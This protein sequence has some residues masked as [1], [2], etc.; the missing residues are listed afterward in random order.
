MK[1]AIAG[2]GI[3]GLSAAMRLRN[4]HDVV[5][6]ERAAEPGGKIHSQSIDGLLF[7]WGPNGF[8]SS[9][10]ALLE[11][12]RELGL[13]SELVE[14]NPAASKRYIFWNGALHALPAKPQ[15]ALRLTL[16]S[17]GG[18]MRA[19]REL[20][21]KA[22]DPPPG[23]SVDAFFRRHFGS[24]VAERIV[25]PALL[26]IT[27][28]DAAKTSVAA[29]FPR[30]VAMER[31][32]GSLL[33]AMARAGGVR[34]KMLGFGASG[35]ER[36]P[37]AMSDAL[38]ERVRFGSA[39][40]SVERTERGWHVICRT[41]STTV[42]AVIVATPADAAASI[43]ERCDGA[44]ARE[45]RRIPY[46]PMRVAGVAFRAKDVPT[47]LDGFGFLA[48]RNQG[49]RILGA[50]YTSTMFPSQAPPDVAYLRVFLG[51]AGDPQAVDLEQAAARGVVLR[52]LRATLGI[53]AQPIAYDEAVWT[54][55]IPQYTL[56]HGEIL[57]NIDARLSAYPGLR[58]IGNAYRGI[59]VGDTAADAVAMADAL[60]RR[61]DHSPS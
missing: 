5:V 34:T 27:A 8:L 60:S 18:K 36:L 58:L 42:D 26:G 31:E 50:L 59:G 43:L 1:I 40:E 12:V 52:D 9:A 44:I 20:F 10:K 7:E 11:I 22:A 56:E 39:V 29:L 6:F 49:V 37:K 54:S 13:E 21:R 33:R 55:A 47:P 4:E 15:E 61:K 41:G 3:A 53:Q 2:G 25:A 24:Q 32:H 35:F 19:L 16:L 48:A 17:T 38:G 30:V 46:A 45:L 51:G 23:E 28:G 57:G 14:A